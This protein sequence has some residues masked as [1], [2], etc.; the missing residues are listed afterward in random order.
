MNQP[1]D[2][3]HQ[4]ISE[5]MVDWLTETDWLIDGIKQQHIREF[6]MFACLFVCT[7]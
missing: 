3:I 5:R 4:W 7:Q 6:E 2:W 1:I